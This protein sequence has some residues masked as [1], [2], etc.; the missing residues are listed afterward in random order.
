MVLKRRTR[1]SLKNTLD[2]VFSRLIRLRD[3]DSTGHGPCITC[4][5]VVF[6]KDADAGHFITRTCVSTRW[7]PLNVNMQCKGCNMAPAG[8]QYEHGLA[9][10]RKHGE[11]TADAIVLKSKIT[12]KYNAQDLAALISIY[13][14]H[15]GNL[16]SAKDI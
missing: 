15:I 3:T 16:E 7:D 9:I 5:K 2:Q 10:D 4:G 11:G 12:A 6:W 14:E 1:S 8:R 13:R